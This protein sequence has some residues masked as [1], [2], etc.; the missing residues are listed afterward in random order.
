MAKKAKKEEAV[1]ETVVTQ[2]IMETPIM[3]TPK[4]IKIEVKKPS[5][6]IKDR[7][8][9]LKDGKTPISRALKTRNIYFFDE[10]KGY[11]REFQYAAKQK[12]CFVDEFKG[13]VKLEHVVFRNGT[14][15]VPRNKQTLQKMLSI[16]HPHKDVLY[17]EL[18]V[19]KNADRDLEYLEMEIAALNAAQ[20]MDVDMAE[21]ILRVEMGSSVSKMSSRELKRDLL[22]FARRNPVLFIELANDE[23]VHLRNVGVKAVEAGIIGL[24][25]DQRN[26]TWISTGRSLMTVPFN[27]HPYSALAAWFK[28]DEGMAV[29]SSVEKQLK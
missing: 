25:Q 24:S 20:S 5:W 26:F 12:T 18:D 11:E 8:Y 17:Q 28:T 4:P 19:V 16:F 7:V 27:E 9:F 23:N 6:E 21:A 15:T 2:E 14:L 10:E 22:M 13:D 1:E 3:E 29:Y